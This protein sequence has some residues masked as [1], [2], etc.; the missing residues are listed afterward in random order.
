MLF[1]LIIYKIFEVVLFI[2][3]SEGCRGLKKLSILISYV[4]LLISNG[5]WIW[6]VLFSFKICIVF[7]V[8]FLGLINRFN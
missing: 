2:F 6:K 3:Y 4:M 1:Y 8:F 5:V 7:Y